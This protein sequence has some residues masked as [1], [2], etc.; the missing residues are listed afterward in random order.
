[1]EKGI[2]ILQLVI[3]VLFLYVY[4]SIFSLQAQF[5]VVF[6]EKLWLQLKERNKVPKD[7]SSEL[8]DTIGLTASRRPSHT[9][10]KDAS[11]NM[12]KYYSF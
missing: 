5:T 8:L 4:I 1:M 12:G 2:S 3:Y 7:F 11:G 9:L 6:V 10:V